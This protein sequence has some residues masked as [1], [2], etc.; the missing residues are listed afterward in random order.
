MKEVLQR[1]SASTPLFFKRL[2][3]LALSA[4]AIATGLVSTPESIA[5]IP[6]T[7]LKVCSNVIWISLVIAS[8]CQLTVKD[9]EQIKKG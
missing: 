5:D 8:M 1:L 7:V 6:D 9:P 4:G 2:R 3:N